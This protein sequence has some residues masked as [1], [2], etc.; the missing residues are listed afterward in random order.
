MSGDLIIRPAYGDAVPAQEEPAPSLC[1]VSLPVPLDQLFTYSLPENLRQ[2]AQAGCRVL[3]PFGKRKL[4]GVILR[5]HD[6]APAGPVK[7]ILKLLD[8]E[9]VLD[10]DLLKLGQWV[11]EYYCAPLGETLRAM[12]PLSGE[13]R[14]GKIYSL[15]ASGRDVARQLHLGDVAPDD[16]ESQILRLLDAR[17]LTES[18]L[19]GKFPKALAILR[20]LHKSGLIEVEDV[21]AER[22]PSA[23]IGR[24]P[25]C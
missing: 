10:T 12:T 3:V 15:T 24:T 1:D 18:S 5:A 7:P 25:A 19:T 17:P 9:P 21:A 8:E 22:D 13:M 16:V 23:R 4:S 20:S 2:R 11:S 6:E 14:R